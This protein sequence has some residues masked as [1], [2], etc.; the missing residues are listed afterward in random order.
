[1]KNFTLILALFIAFIGCANAIN[2]YFCANCPYPFNAKLSSVTVS[3]GSMGYCARKSSSDQA[4]APNSRGPA[5][6]GLC[7]APGCRWQ[8]DPASGRQIYVC[9]CATDYCNCG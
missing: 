3:V 1:M 7:T 9:C 5:E 6:A 2:C 4:S 8:Y